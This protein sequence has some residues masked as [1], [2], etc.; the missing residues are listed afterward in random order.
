M[1]D[2]IDRRLMRQVT[3]VLKSESDNFIDLVRVA[4]LDPRTAF[5]GADLEGIDLTG[6]DLR[7]FN[8]KGANLSGAKTEG[9]LFAVGYS[10]FDSIELT[11]RDLFAFDDTPYANF[12]GKIL[13]QKRSYHR[14]AEIVAMLCDT[15]EKSLILNVIGAMKNG[16]RSIMVFRVC[17]VVQDL[18]RDH[19][20][21]IYV[22]AT[23][24]AATKSA[25]FMDRR[26]VLNAIQERC[27]NYVLVESY[28]RNLGKT[29]QPKWL[30]EKIGAVLRS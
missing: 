8:F 22:P 28:L 5:V 10:P 4:K 15:T 27:G 26:R 29:R 2:F 7:E 19:G 9:T 30:S 12:L 16:E 1:K 23:I 13:S 25:H 20:Q 17:R 6:L 21:S 3:S 14:I 24:S 11:Q 18:V